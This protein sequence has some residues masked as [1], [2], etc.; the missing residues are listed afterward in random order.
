MRQEMGSWCAHE[1]S[2]PWDSADESELLFIP[3]LKNWS[4]IPKSDWRLKSSGS[5]PR[6]PQDPQE[7][8]PDTPI[9]RVMNSWTLPCQ[10]ETD[11]SD[12][13]FVHVGET[14]VRTLGVCLHR[15]SRDTTREGWRSQGELSRSVICRTSVLR[16][17]NT[18]AS[19][20][21]AANA[22]R[23]SGHVKRGLC[24]LPSRSQ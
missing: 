14:N 8:G 4:S 1:G 15:K 9:I 2:S 13:K 3:T 19:L 23:D 12:S 11:D 17:P 7:P 21:C 18:Q 20:F 24:G 22:L 6:D 10:E 16:L 5:F